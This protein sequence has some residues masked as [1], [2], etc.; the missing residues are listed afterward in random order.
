MS[1]TISDNSDNDTALIRLVL[2]QNDQLQAVV[3]Y[4]PFNEVFD[5]Q[6]DRRCYSFS[7]VL[8]VMVNEHGFLGE[9][10]H[11]ENA[12]KDYMDQWYPLH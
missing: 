5:I 11:M 3:L 10:G 7:E 2:R 9:T 1:L 8:E 4:Y 6:L 12:F